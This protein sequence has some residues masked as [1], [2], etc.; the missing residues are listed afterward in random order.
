M[1]FCENTLNKCEVANY[2]NITQ[3]FAVNFNY[4]YFILFQPRSCCKYLLII[5]F[6]FICNEQDCE[7]NS[8]K[9]N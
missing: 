4:L 6:I 2:S 3:D 8:L 1:A 5:N 9:N 7:F